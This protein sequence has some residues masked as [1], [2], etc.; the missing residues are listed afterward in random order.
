MEPKDFVSAEQVVS[1]LSSHADLRLAESVA[2]S[3]RAREWALK[4]RTRM[5]IEANLIPVVYA[6]GGASSSDEPET[7]FLEPG[8]EVSVQPPTAALKEGAIAVITV[9]S[10][11]TALNRVLEHAGFVHWSSRYRVLRSVSFDEDPSNDS[12]WIPAGLWLLPPP[13]DS[14]RYEI[15]VDEGNLTGLERGATPRRED[16]DVKP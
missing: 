4:N 12:P 11:F 8:A 6:S 5:W 13:S 7:V 15:R 16:R 10:T 9:R 14:Q 2:G 1:L 3:G